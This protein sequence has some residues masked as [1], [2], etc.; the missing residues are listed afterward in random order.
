MAIKPGNISR[1]AG[2]GGYKTG[3]FAQIVAATKQHNQIVS[4][5]LKLSM[6]SVPKFLLGAY[7]ATALD[8]AVRLTKH[9]SSRFA[10][11]WNLSVGKQGPLNDGNPDPIKYNES[12]E[13]FGTIGTK[14]DAKRFFIRVLTA[15]RMYYGYT[16]QTKGSSYMMLT[17]GRLAEALFPRAGDKVQYAKNG[18]SLANVKLTADEMA[19]EAPAIYL[20]NAFMRPDSI[21]SRLDGAGR[22]YPENALFK[23]GATPLKEEVSKVMGKGLLQEVLVKLAAEMRAANAA[24]KIVRPMP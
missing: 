23:E 13:S 2:V 3:K 6:A 17:K 5:N 4:A 19:G 11:N 21:N 14:G 22:S 16:N 12:G 10:A 18:R 9:D 15:K 24:N 20:Y 1:H 7:A 8:T